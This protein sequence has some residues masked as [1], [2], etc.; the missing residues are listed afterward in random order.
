MHTHMAY[1]RLPTTRDSGGVYYQEGNGTLILERA[2]SSDNGLYECTGTNDFG[3][4]VART[5]LT[6]DR[7]GEK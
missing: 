1:D 2:D 4:D 7:P 5:Q 3:S 6:F